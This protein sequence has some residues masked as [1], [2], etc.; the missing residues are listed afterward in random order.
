MVTWSHHGYSVTMVTGSHH[1]NTVWLQFHEITMAIPLP[2]CIGEDDLHAAVGGVVCPLPF[3]SVA[4]PNIVGILL[5]KLE[6]RVVDTRH[7][8]LGLPIGC[9]ANHTLPSSH[10]TAASSSLTLSGSIF[11]VNS[12]L[13]KAS[14]CS[15]VSPILLRKRPYCSR[16]K[17]RRWWS[18]RKDSCRCRMQGG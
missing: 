2:R 17:W 9:Y 18:L 13:Q 3:L 14:A 4:V 5:L 12:V 8:K 6:S 1:G 11:L 10:N 7:E 15:S 16:P